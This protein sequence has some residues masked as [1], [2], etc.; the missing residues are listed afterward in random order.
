MRGSSEEVWI[1]KRR[2]GKRGLQ[3]CERSGDLKMTNKAVVLDRVK[4]GTKTRRKV[5]GG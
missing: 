2:M 4:E 1:K 3:E 5:K